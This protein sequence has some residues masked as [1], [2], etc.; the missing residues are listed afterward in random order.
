MLVAGVQVVD[1]VFIYTFG[2][3]ILVIDKI[4]IRT[5]PFPALPYT[6][7]PV[8]ELKVLIPE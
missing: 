3:A 6:E 1:D 4:V 8:G 2:V 7:T 5:Y